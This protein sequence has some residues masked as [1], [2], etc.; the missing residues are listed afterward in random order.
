M[1]KNRNIGI[2]LAVMILLVI[3]AFMLISLFSKPVYE[4]KFN[5]NGG[6]EI[7]SIKVKA[8][9]TV[10]KP[11]TPNKE[12]Y[13]FTGWYLEDELFDFETKIIKD[14]TLTAKW[15][16]VGKAMVTIRFDTLEGSK[17]EDKTIPYG[18]TLKAIPNPTKEDYIF[19][20]WYYQ[21]KVFDFSSP[22]MEDITLVAKWKKDTTKKYTVSF[23][24]DG[25]SKIED[26]SVKEGSTITPPNVPTKEGYKFIGWYLEEK[27]FDFTKAIKENVKL[28]AKWK[29]E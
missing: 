28:K 1:N 15:Q 27:E 21:N 29:K 26:I 2:F 10:T 6:S 4:V 12:G 19:A 18:E 22:I 9:E 14:I 3:A 25:A 20:G 11:E 7:A 13:Y 8:K 16:E 5:T 23:D 24:T 17:V